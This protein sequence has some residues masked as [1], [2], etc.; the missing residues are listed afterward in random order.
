M[1]EGGHGSAPMLVEP[2]LLGRARCAS[3]AYAVHLFGL[4]S[5]ADVGAAGYTTFPER[6][7]LNDTACQSRTGWLR[8]VIAGKEV[9]RFGSVLPLPDLS[10]FSGGPPDVPGVPRFPAG[11]VASMSGRSEI[12]VSLGINDGTNERWLSFDVG[13]TIDFVAECATAVF[14]APTGYI[15]V[16]TTVAPVAQ[17]GLAIDTFLSVHFWEIEEPLQPRGHFTTSRFVLA[18][19][20]VTI[21]VPDGAR[22]FRIEQSPLGAAA[23]NWVG[24]YGDPNVLAGA[25]PHAVFSFVPGSRTTPFFEIG[26]TTHIRSDL[27]AATDRF[28]HVVWQIEP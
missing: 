27:D 3:S 8:A 26:D 4:V 9:Q 12:K 20:Q 1:A 17:N 21:P 18:G 10:Y 6:R 11:I 23:A 19:T 28:F 16:S 7:G 5:P 15:D 13:Q 22:G 24:W 14:H 25:I 2:V